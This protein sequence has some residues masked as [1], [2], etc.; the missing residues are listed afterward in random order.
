MR[1]PK[2]KKLHRF[3]SFLA[4]KEKSARHKSRESA[5]TQIDVYLSIPRRTAKLSTESLNKLSA[6][7]KTDLTKNR[8]KKL[9]SFSINAA[10]SQQKSK[11]RIPHT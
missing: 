3:Y 10:N 4:Q 1:N 9:T 8:N 11:T 7:S 6:M 2:E 5:S